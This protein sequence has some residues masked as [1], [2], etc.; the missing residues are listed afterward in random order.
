V[1]VRV[2]AYFVLFILWFHELQDGVSAAMVALEA[3]SWLG[4]VFLAGIFG[5][6]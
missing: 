5:P 6:T 2:E 1:E 4:F 3:T